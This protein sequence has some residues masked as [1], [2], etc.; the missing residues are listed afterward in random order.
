M[1]V[2]FGKCITGPNYSPLFFTVLPFDDVLAGDDSFLAHAGYRFRARCQS[3]VLLLYAWARAR[4]TSPS[5]PTV[6]ACSSSR[7]KHV[8]WINHWA[9]SEYAP[10]CQA[11][12]A[13]S[14]LYFLWP[15]RHLPMLLSHSTPLTRHCRHC[16]RRS[17]YVANLLV[18]GNATDLLCHCP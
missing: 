14:C 3:R 2:D 13:P 8:H 4:P 9:L 15:D 18:E 5:H 12:L 1:I 17:P 11:N 10:S 7:V 6:H 16:Q